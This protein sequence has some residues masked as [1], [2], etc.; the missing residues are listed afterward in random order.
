[1]RITQERTVYKQCLR[2]TDENPGKGDFREQMLLHNRIS[3]ILEVEV[4]SVN[5]ERIYEYS[6]QNYESLSQ[7]CGKK[8]IESG[9]LKKIMSGILD[10]VFR[11]REYMLRE[12]DFVLSPESIFLDR[13][14]MPHIAYFPEYGMSF[15]E[16]L[17]SL[18][19]FFLDHIEYTDEN[20]VITVYTFYSKTKVDSCRIEELA[21]ILNRDDGKKTREHSEPQIGTEQPEKPAKAPVNA[22][23]KV[24]PKEENTTTVDRIRNRQVLKYTELGLAAVV[25]LTEIILFASEVIS[26]RESKIKAVLA[27]AGGAFFCFEIIKYGRI[28]REKLEVSRAVLETS[29]TEHL[30]EATVYLDDCEKKGEISLISQENPTIEVTAF[31]FVIGKDKNLS[32]YVLDRAGISRNHLKLEKKGSIIFASDMNSTNGTFVNGSRLK[33]GVPQ[34][35]REGDQIRL[36]NI[37]YYYNCE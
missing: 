11:S 18:A 36:A 13:E 15:R 33:P 10:I 16:Q 8:R 4:L 5:A 31:P 21:E 23:P 9:E 14:G 2:I 22:F 20:A 27:L 28:L 32:D 3:G 29:V 12:D 7:R 34:E 24:L 25:V 30:E 37:S 1:M 17:R 35:I 26:F 19:E 6:I